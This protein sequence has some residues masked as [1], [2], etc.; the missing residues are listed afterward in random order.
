M[1]SL[2]GF[3]V[4][5]T[6]GGRERVGGGGDDGVVVGVQ[7]FQFRCGAGCSCCWAVLLELDECQLE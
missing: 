5:M 6:G 7:S 4:W 2:T 1:M 3:D